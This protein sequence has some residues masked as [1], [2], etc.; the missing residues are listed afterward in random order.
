MEASTRDADALKGLQARLDRLVDSAN[1]SAAT[2][3][4][5]YAAEGLKRATAVALQLHGDTASLVAAH[6]RLKHALL[7]RLQAFS[8]GVG[9][10]EKEALDAEALALVL[11]VLPLLARRLDG[12][13][14]L[15][16]ACTQEE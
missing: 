12:G 16:G 6:L 9:R 14:L 2:G 4:Y 15:P 7:L 1:A 13:T 5:A 10:L 3:R 8:D 11:L